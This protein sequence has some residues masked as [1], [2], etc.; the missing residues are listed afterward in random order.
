M[1]RCRPACGKVVWRRGRAARPRRWPRRAR[2]FKYGK[3]LRGRRPGAGTARRGRAT[4]PARGAERRQR[5]GDSRERSAFHVREEPTPTSARV[6]QGSL[7]RRR[8]GRAARAEPDGAAVVPPRGA[9]QVTR[10]LPVE[11]EAPRPRS[12]AAVRRRCP[13]RRFSSAPGARLPGGG[14][15]SD[16]QAG[17]TPRA[18]SM[19]RA[20]AYD[21]VVAPKVDE[22][23]RPSSSFLRATGSAVRHT[24]VRQATHGTQRRRAS[25]DPCCRPKSPHMPRPG[26]AAASEPPSQRRRV[27][28]RDAVAQRVRGFCVAEGASRGRDSLRGGYVHS[29][30]LPP[31]QRREG[32][33]RRRRRV[34]PHARAGGSPRR[35]HT[36]SISFNRP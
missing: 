4:P 28:R 6:K 34:W 36:G 33:L 12:H 24:R 21:R 14:G 31:R 35:T 5:V 8:S 7:R 29:L 30:Y 26:R 19:S 32:S 18:T 20:P 23:P 15:A 25:V 22:R 27:P 10:A 11:P 13:A 2:R 17:A 3:P 16:A 1:H 9:R